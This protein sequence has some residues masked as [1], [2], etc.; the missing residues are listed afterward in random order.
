M[1]LRHVFLT[2][3]MELMI[4]EAVAMPEAVSLISRQ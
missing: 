2:Y 4:E 3:R 1:H